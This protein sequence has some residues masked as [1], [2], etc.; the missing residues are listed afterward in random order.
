[1]DEEAHLVIYDPK[2]SRQQILRYAKL[3]T[4]SNY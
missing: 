1:M 4:H 3:L 2:V